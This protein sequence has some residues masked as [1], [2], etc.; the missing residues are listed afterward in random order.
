LLTKVDFSGQDEVVW[1]KKVEKM[2]KNGKNIA[3]KNFTFSFS[4]IET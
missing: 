2:G 1:Q 3:A 4:I